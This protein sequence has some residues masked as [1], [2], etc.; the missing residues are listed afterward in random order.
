MDVWS[1]GK[2]IAIAGGTG[3]LGRQLIGDLLAHDNHVIV[4]SRSSRKP[5][6]LPEKVQFATWNAATDPPPHDAL[7]GADIVFNLVGENIGAGRW[8]SRRKSEI[9][10]SRLETTTKIVNALGPRTSVLINASAISFYPGDGRRYPEDGP[11]PLG[12]GF[13]QNMTHE[14]ERSAWQAQ[15][16]GPIRVVLARIGMVLGEEGML[17]GMLPLF[18]WCMGKYLGDIDAQVPWIHVEDVSRLLGFLAERPD[19]CGAFNVSNPHPIV[20]SQLSAEVQ[21]LM[22]RR[23]FVGLSS[24][25]IRLILGPD[26]SDLLLARHDL[27]PTKA[28]NL[29]FSFLH[30]DPR[31]T[32]A[33]SLAKLG[34][35]A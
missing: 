2:R 9:S 23:S 13:I 14:W 30:D 35:S 33:D 19:A 21:R 31:A 26:A 20:F 6:N 22:N 34:A 4:L 17:K 10:R 7:D 12:S 24:N 32:I 15:G 18:R 3:F 25:V 28:L 11:V 27:L 8:S 5:S 29:G 1:T 16:K